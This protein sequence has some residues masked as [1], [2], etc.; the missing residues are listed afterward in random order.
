LSP[1]LLGSWWE[2]RL[3]LVSAISLIAAL[4]VTVAFALV[5][6]RAG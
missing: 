5:N 4:A 6:L 2:R 1:W 3:A